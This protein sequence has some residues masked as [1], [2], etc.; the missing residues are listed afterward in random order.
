[1]IENDERQPPGTA[2]EHPCSIRFRGG[3]QVSYVQFERHGP[4]S[5]YHFSGAG[6]DRF[7]KARQSGRVNRIALTP[8]SLTRAL[9]SWLRRP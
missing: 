3:L 7:P 8:I 1:M 6:A 2:S 9:P 4:A 5:D